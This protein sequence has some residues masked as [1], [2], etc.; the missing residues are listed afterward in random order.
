MSG[1]QGRLNYDLL[2]EGFPGRTSADIHG[3]MD[4][5]FRDHSPRG[6]DEIEG[7]GSMASRRGISALNMVLELEERTSMLIDTIRHQIRSIIHE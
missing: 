5:I 6:L 4:R 1:S 7:Q 2:A 3:E